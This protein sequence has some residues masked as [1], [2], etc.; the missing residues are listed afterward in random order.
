[1]KIQE[2]IQAAQKNIEI[3][4]QGSLRLQDRIQSLE[5]KVGNTNINNLQNR[6]TTLQEDI[7]KIHNKV[8]SIEAGLRDRYLKENS[9]AAPK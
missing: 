5:I 7:A 1:M 6:I 9:E 4:L 8:I 2:E 3:I